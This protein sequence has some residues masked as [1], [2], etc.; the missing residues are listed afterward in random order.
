MIF[1]ED[2]RHPDRIVVKTHE[3]GGEGEPTRPG[4]IVEQR[5]QEQGEQEKTPKNTNKK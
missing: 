3:S 5:K 2:I 1:A 4:E